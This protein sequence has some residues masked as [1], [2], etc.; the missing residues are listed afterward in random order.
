MRMQTQKR[1]LLTA[2]QGKRPVIFN[3]TRLMGRM[4]SSV[5][6]GVDRLDIRYARYFLDSHDVRP[7][8]FV[9]QRKNSLSLIPAVLS[10]FLID[11]LWDNWMRPESANE[12][13]TLYRERAVHVLAWLKTAALGHVSSGIDPALVKALRP[14]PRPIYINAGHTGVQH[15][16]VHERI[17]DVLGADMVYYLHDLIPIDYPEYVRTAA[18]ADIHAT[19]VAVMVK[20]GSLILTNSHY[21]RDRFH[22]YCREGQVNPPDCEVIEIG[23][24]DTI[25]DAAGFEKKCLPERVVDRLDGGPYFAVV[26]TIEPRKNH[27]ML[28]QIWRQLARDLGSLCP[29][30]VLVGRRGWEN[31]NVIDMLDRCPGVK[32]HVIELNDLTDCE[33]I[34]VV[35]N[36]VATLYPNF[37]EG[38]GIPVTESLSLGTPVICSNIPALRECSQGKAIF[39]H[40]LDGKGWLQVIKD[41]TQAK[42]AASTQEVVE[43][44]HQASREFEPVTWQVHIARLEELLN[45]LDSKLESKSA[46]T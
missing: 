34:P 18:Y 26:G 45:V 1:A 19:R 9:H 20:T 42:N 10:R 40:P 8:F 29:K 13:G 41:M 17:R 28:L 43:R 44:V 36:A 31:E 35:Q 30:L 3:L 6:T 15:T 32:K 12:Q 24:E 33:M 11:S 7:V 23:V 2:E 22:R 4:Y 21:T 5:P 46:M 14:A 39:L 25:L 38:W 27:L 16:G 37:E